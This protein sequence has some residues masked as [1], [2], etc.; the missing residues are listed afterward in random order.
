MGFTPYRGKEPIV[1]SHLIPPII[2]SNRLII[3][4]FLDSFAVAPCASSDKHRDIPNATTK[5]REE[6]PCRD[7]AREHKN[8]AGF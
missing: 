1:L 2:S 8:I 5:A 4:Y 3:Y 6:I 7:K